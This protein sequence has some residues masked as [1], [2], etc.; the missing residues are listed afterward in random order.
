MPDYSLEKAAALGF[1]AVL[2]EGTI[3][4]YGK[5]G[6]CH[7]RDFGIRYHGIPEGADAS[8]FLGKELIPGYLRGAC[9][10]YQT[11]QGYYADASEMREFG[12][13]FPFKE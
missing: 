5:S 10:V 4:L 2:F 7:A 1:G 11:P 6:F 12:R 8:F 9:G 13:H 3:A